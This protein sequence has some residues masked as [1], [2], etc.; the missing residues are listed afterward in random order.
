MTRPITAKVY[1]PPTY[2][3][4]LIPRC[5]ALPPLAL[6]VNMARVYNFDVTQRRKGGSGAD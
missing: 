6:K 5:L 2:S 1:Q 4:R 3:H